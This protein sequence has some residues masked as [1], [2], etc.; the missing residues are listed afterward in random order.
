MNFSIETKEKIPFSLFLT[1]KPK[2]NNTSTIL[3]EKRD[4]ELES[5][6][7]VKNKCL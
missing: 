2:F 6:L 5:R 3:K 1:R 4:N 7:R